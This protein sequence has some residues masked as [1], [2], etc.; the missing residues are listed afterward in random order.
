MLDKEHGIPARRGAGSSNT[1]FLGSIGDHNVVIACL[2]AGAPGAELAA[3]VV[4]NMQHTFRDVR[5]GL[6]VGVGSGAP[7]A[8]DDIRLGN[9]VVSRP[10]NDTGGVV[11]FGL[12]PGDGDGDDNASSG[13]SGSASSRFVR[14]RCLNAPPRVLLSALSVLQAEHYVGGSRVSDILAGAA[15]NYPQKRSLFAVPVSCSRRGGGE[16]VRKVL[17]WLPWTTA[18][19]A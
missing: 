9:V 8:A 10:T 5:V 13:G 2:P 12:E 11:Q 6:L 4:A 17:D 7:S 1:Y 3:T 15:Q 16:E 19:S 18:S 14:T